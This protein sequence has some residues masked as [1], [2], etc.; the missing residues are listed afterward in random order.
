MKR[1]FTIFLSSIVGISLWGQQSLPMTIVGDV[2]NGGNMKSM[3][4]VHIKTQTLASDTG[5]VANYGNL[6][7][8]DGVIFYSNDLSD[9]LLL[10]GANVATA[11]VKVRKT[12]E[13]D[14][15]WYMM[16]FPFDVDVDNGI[17]D[18]AT[19]AK[20]VRGTNFQVQEYDA[21]KR[22]DNGTRGTGNSD[23]STWKLLD[24]NTIKKGQA[25][26][27]IVRQST[28]GGGN[29]VDFVSNS[30]S[31]ITDLFRSGT[32]N[33]GL[34]F[35]EATNRSTDIDDASEGW[36][37]IGGLN[38]TNYF[39]SAGAATP[40]V[41]FNGTEGNQVVYYWDG[42]GD[43][44]DILLTLEA[45][46]LRPYGV[47]FV[48]TNSKS[49]EETNGD[50][51]AYN[52]NANSKGSDSGVT[53]DISLGGSPTFRSS[54]STSTDIVG[55]WLT[56]GTNNAKFSR[57]YFQFNET[58]SKLYLPAEDAVRMQTQS[59][60]G[61]PVV[62]SL[63]KDAENT[64]NNLF[65]NSLPD[66]ENEVPLGINVPAAGDY[67]FSMKN[68]TDGNITS[69]VLWDKVADKRTNLLTDDYHLQASGA[70]NTDDRFV[71][72]FS[73][74]VTS[75]DP[76]AKVSEIYAYADNNVLT[77]KNLLPGD[78]VQV[79]DLTGRI[80]A[81]GVASGNTYSVNL[82]QKGVYIVNARGGKTLKVLNK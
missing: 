12:F 81:S 5:K 64:N 33:V 67:V 2:Y 38:S 36:N 1:L 54:Q 61:E 72:F 49:I 16:S 62:W 28:L 69:A 30:T 22:A 19:G 60:T 51:F 45:G 24:G 82:S 15:T 13:R 4:T 9:G 66:D 37:A 56:D 23:A 6:D 70:M 3:G 73:K 55:L 59:S 14:N 78:K 63:A 76:T 21:Q 27:V 8:E 41:S 17:L 7:M 52:S 25:C 79:L 43:W 39:V 75:I 42:S 34:T 26:R 47:I 71:L 58:F 77:V 80:I 74:V 57:I 32:K 48:Q 31:D 68:M 35:A 20:L 46:T 40:T 10:N 18:P 50:L 65:V 53:L 44:K 11:E 29:M